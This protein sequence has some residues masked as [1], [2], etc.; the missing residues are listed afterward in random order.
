MPLVQ[1]DILAGEKSSW[2]YRHSVWQPESNPRTASYWPCNLPQNE[3]HCRPTVHRVT[4]DNER[5]VISA[6]PG[7]A[8]TLHSQTTSNLYPLL[9]LFLSQRPHCTISIACFNTKVMC[10]HA[11]SCLTF[12]NPKDSSPPGSSDHGIFQARILKQ[13][14]TS[15]SRG[16]SGPR[17]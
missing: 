6:I 10:M 15:Y 1:L 4:W 13:V 9:S 3:E 2:A 16:S 8:T 12:C 11:Q 5:T 7:K 17:D 14:A